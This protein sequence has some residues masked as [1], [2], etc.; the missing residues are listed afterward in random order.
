MHVP[1]D[2]LICIA[3]YNA[4][5]IESLI[6][7]SICVMHCRHTYNAS[8]RLPLQKVMGSR[9]PDSDCHLSNQLLGHPEKDL[10]A[11]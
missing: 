2:A 9:G 6:Q 3:W 1:K 4:W 11:I 10:T 5:V 7:Y 8:R